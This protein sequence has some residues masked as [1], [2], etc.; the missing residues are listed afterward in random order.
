MK[1]GSLVLSLLF[2]LTSCG[3]VELN[4]L[5]IVSGLGFD[6]SPEGISMQLQIVNPG[7]TAKSKGATDSGGSGGAVY[8]YTITGPTVTDIMEKARNMFSRKLYFAHISVI[9]AGEEFAKTKGLLPIIDYL[10]RYYQIRDNVN[11]F[12]AKGNSAKDLFHVYI[13]IQNMPALSIARR[14]DVYGGSMGLKKGIEFQDVLRWNYGGYTE[15]V[16]PGIQKT[17]PADASDSAV[18][19]NINGNM[20]MFEMTGF[21]LFQDSKLIGW[22]SPGESRGWGLLKNMVDVFE[23]TVECP[24]YPNE[25]IGLKFSH[26]KGKLKNISIDPLEYEAEVS[27]TAEVGEVTCPIVLEKGDGLNRIEKSAEKKLQEEMQQAFQT[28]ISQKTDVIGLRQLLYENHYKEWLKRKDQWDDM[29]SRARLKTKAT[30][31]V[32]ITGLRVKSI[33]EK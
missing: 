15:P 33:Y 16:I 24:G 1:R 11:V 17:T 26:T 2:I 9:V 8:S 13:P 22:Y 6:V 14:V 21:A 23:T 4:E 30:V 7:A 3:R 31:N 12:I 25:R 32:Q 28:A 10:E 5:A 19:N 27:A 20:K 29:F 18:L